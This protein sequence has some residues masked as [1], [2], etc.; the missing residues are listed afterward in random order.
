MRNRHSGN[1]CP[2]AQSRCKREADHRPDQQPLAPHPVGQPARNRRSIAEATY[3]L[4]APSYA[5]LRRAEARLHVR[6]RHVGDGRATLDQPPRASTRCDQRSLHGRAVARRHR[7]GLALAARRGPRGRAQSRIIYAR[8]LLPHRDRTGTRCSPCPNCPLAFC[9]VSPEIHAL[10]RSDR[11]DM[12]RS[13]DARIA[14]TFTPAGGRRPFWA[15]RLPSNWL[16]PK[17]ACRDDHSIATP[18]IALLPPEQPSDGRPFA[19]RA[20][21]T[22]ERVEPGLFPRR[23]AAA[24]RAGC[25]SAQ[26]SRC[27]VDL[28]GHCRARFLP[29]QFVTAH[30]ISLGVKPS[31]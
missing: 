31:L 21:I 6:Q 4:S 28:R 30:L 14:S 18:V 19:C 22:C 24:T 17:P 25:R 1:E 12:G 8:R 2:S 16:R 7:V 3:R 10:S 27:L 11:G 15:G 13:S 9:A 26:R 20:R 5:F 23:Q 29:G